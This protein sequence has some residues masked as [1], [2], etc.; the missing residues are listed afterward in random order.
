MANATTGNAGQDLLNI[1][2]RSQGG[3]DVFSRE[4]QFDVAG[5]LGGVFH[6]VEFRSNLTPSVQIRM[7]DLAADAPASPWGRL[8]QPTVV[9][10]GPAGQT[11]IAPMGESRDGVGLVVGLA[12]V[13]ALLGAGF[14]LGRSSKRG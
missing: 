5:L 6:A 10:Y 3:G 2:S 9:F 8:L 13:A 11:T 14:M 7:A 12:V 1:L 4:G